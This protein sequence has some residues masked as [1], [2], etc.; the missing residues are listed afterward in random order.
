MR[1]PKVLEVLTDDGRALRVYDTGGSDADGGPVLLWFHGTPQTGEP[2]PPLLTELAR[3]GIRC[4]SYDR[5][6]YRGTPAR[7]KTSV[8]PAV[9]DAEAVA[10]GL[11]LGV[12]A[13]M[14]L[15]SGGAYALACAALLPDRV[16]AAVTVA[17]PAPIDAAGL[18]WFAGMGPAATARMGSGVH[19]REAVE[20]HLRTVGFASDVPTRSDYLALIG[21]WSCLGEMS[22]NAMATGFRGAV[23]DVLT[24]VTP[25]GFA[26]AE[27]T[28]PVLVVHGAADRIV[29]SRHAEWLARQLGG[30]ELRLWPGD[31]HVAVVGACADALDWLVAQNG[32]SDATDGPSG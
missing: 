11:G 3:R 7:P 16:T 19:G 30:A 23:D 6:G 12:F 29:P 8:A 26:P 21:E 27:V 24:M 4:V 14:G 2:L 9:A 10:D 1:S 13:T 32:A 22:Q 28:V 31:G 25:W 18:D 15:S 5:P 17:S 20:N